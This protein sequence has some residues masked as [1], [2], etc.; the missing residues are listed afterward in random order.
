MLHRTNRQSGFSLI[1]LIAAVAILLVL[2]GVVVPAIGGKVEKARRVRAMTDLRHVAEAFN[3]Y[4]ADTGTWPAD[5]AFDP[6]VTTSVDFLR[7]TCLYT[8]PTGIA[9]WN[10]PYMTDG[11]ANGTTMQAAYS[12]SGTTGGLLDPWGHPYV[13]HFFARGYNSS[14]GA[15]VLASKGADGTADAT[16]TQL[17]GGQLA[18]DDLVMMVTRK[19]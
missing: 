13:V 5:G 2:A 11:Y 12:S 4:R 7:F 6:T 10:G 8:A 9:N 16:A 19:L 17:W 15:I 14:Q 1:E 18:D 3:T